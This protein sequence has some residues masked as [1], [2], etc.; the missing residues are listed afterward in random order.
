MKGRTKPRGVIGVYAMRRS[1]NSQ[2]INVPHK[3]LHRLQAG[4]GYKGVEMI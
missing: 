4:E 2:K 3:N 1:A